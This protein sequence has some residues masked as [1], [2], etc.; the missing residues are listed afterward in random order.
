MPTRRSNVSRMALA[1]CLVALTLSAC[2]KS[3]TDGGQPATAPPLAAL[4]LATAA[5][6]APA[7][8]A[9]PAAA[10]QAEP[11]HIRVGLRRDSERYGYVDRA[12]AMSRAFGDTPPDYTVDYAGTRPWVWRSDDGSFR[13]VEQ[14][15]EGQRTYYYARGADSPFYIT[16]SEGGYAYDGDTLVGVYGPNGAPLGDSYAQRWSDNA[17]R[18]YDRSRVI[19]HAANY[20]QRQSAYAEQWRARRDGIAQQ[21]RNWDE[22]RARD[23]EWQAWHN[24]HQQDEDRDW[25]DEQ[26]RR[27]AYA[28]AVGATIAG[29]AALVSG[30]HPD[31]HDNG[32]PPADGQRYGGGPGAP[33][34]GPGAGNGQRPNG[35]NGPNGNV[36]P[37]GAQSRGPQPGGMPPGGPQS[38]GFA[39]PGVGGQP[40]GHSQ[41]VVNPTA[42]HPAPVIQHPG[43]PTFAP[44]P[45]GAGS[46]RPP[47]LPMRPAPQP[48]PQAPVHVAPPAH[49]VAPRVFSP[50]PPPPVVRAPVRP[51]APAARQE[52]LPPPRLRMAPPPPAAIARPAFEAPAAMPRRPIESVPVHAP[53]PPPMPE[54]IRPVPVPVAPR[55]AL[56]APPA[57]PNMPPRMQIAEPPRHGPPSDHHTD[58]P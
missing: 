15:P 11:S 5:P 57:H 25:Q 9:P 54:R 22:A 44:P 14:L 13:I 55:P 46:A 8:Y 30:N 33:G 51:V 40:A 1:G 12:Y 17:A 52:P 56:A 20:S 24:Q 36:Q 32:P 31:H 47:I 27:A 37:G 28:V 6:T 4:P 19:Y 29:V 45:A 16:D 7:T 50:A 42:P 23:A 18:Y 43:R 34:Y 26:N 49:Q 53:P 35:P 58:K 39:R 21:Q 38:G 48:M 10:L 41:P 3:N 2:Q